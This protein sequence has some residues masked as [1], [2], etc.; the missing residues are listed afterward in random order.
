MQS[1]AGSVMVP[2]IEHL[3]GGSLDEVIDGILFSKS[4]AVKLQVSIAR[5]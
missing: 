3:P 4:L 1:L 5:R 2:Q